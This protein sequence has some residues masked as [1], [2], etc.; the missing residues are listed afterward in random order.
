MNISDKNLVIDV[1]V[2]IHMEK[3]GLLEQLL[4]VKKLR[5]ID[6]VFHE[7]Y[8]HKP[9]LSTRSVKKIRRVGLNEKQIKEAENMKKLGFFDACIFIYARDNKCSILSGDGRLRNIGVANDI[10]VFGIIW[11]VE[12][13]NK[14]GIISIEELKQAYICWIEDPRVFIP[15]EILSDKLEELKE[16][17]V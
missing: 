7:E 14:H 3:A 13:M 11:L 17:S 1:N 9:N 15:E 2:I 10:E 16:V 4:K 5:I 8:Q 12:Q 6:L